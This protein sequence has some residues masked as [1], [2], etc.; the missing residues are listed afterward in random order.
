MLLVNWLAGYLVETKVAK[1]AHPMA[2]QT[3]TA[4]LQLTVA[5]FLILYQ[6]SKQRAELMQVFKNVKRSP[7]PAGL[8]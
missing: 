3:Q 1:W 5:I 4:T 6:V 7:K 8:L 2:N